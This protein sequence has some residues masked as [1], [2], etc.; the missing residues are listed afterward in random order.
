[1]KS[2]L[3]QKWLEALETYPKTKGCLKNSKG[4]CCLG[5]LAEIT[6]NLM[7]D[8]KGTGWVEHHYG[9]LPFFVRKELGLS[10]N[11]QE[12][13][14]SLNDKNDTFKEVMEYIKNEI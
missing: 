11:N 4:Y 7:V 9:A 6:G 8:E 5:V 2:E 12:S 14:I 3:K 1:M 13:L 10:S